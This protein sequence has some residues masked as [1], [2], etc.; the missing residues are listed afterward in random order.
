MNVLIISDNL[1]L[2]R[3]FLGQ[4]ARPEISAIA[5]VELRHAGKAPSPLGELGASRVDLTDPQQVN[6]IL[7]EFELVISAHCKKI[8]PPAL[9]N[10]VRCVNYHPGLNPYNRGWYPQVFSILNGKPLGATVHEMTEEIDGG[11][12]IAQRPV[13]L[14]SADT[15]GTA[16][17]KV[18]EAEKELIRDTLLDVVAGTYAG[19]APECPGNYNGIADFRGLLRFDLEHEGS[20]REHLDLLRALSHPPFW[21]AYFLDEEGKKVFV[22]VE[23]RGE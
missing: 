4:F 9:V 7:H 13:Q 2:A 1:D 22:R 15:S 8:F 5:C 10:G 21:N 14:S 16:Y 12:I 6:A 19:R 11:P 18:I 17:A 3:F 20:L 23:M